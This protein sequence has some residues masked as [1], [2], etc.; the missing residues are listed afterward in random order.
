MQKRRPVNFVK[1]AGEIL[2]ERNKVHRVT[3]PA[4]R[5][6]AAAKP[7]ERKEGAVTRGRTGSAR[8]VRSKSPGGGVNDAQAGAKTAELQAMLL[9]SRIGALKAMRE[10]ELISD[11]DFETAKVKCLM[12]FAEG[13]LS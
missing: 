6:R 3:P 1:E 11:A 5:P 8:M 9:E 4:K 2:Y 12:H 7:R 10:K 13:T